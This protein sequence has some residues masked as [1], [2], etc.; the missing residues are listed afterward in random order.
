M[1]TP[2]SLAFKLINF[3]GLLIRIEILK[4]KIDFKPLIQLLIQI[5]K[6]NQAHQMS[7]CHIH[8]L[9]MTKKFCEIYCNDYLTVMP[10]KL[11]HNFI[12]KY[13]TLY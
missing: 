4:I 2:K 7:N 8:K 13:N 9:L 10:F 11:K 6:T 3:C 12:L 1:E 5:V